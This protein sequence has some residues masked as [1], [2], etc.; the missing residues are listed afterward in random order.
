MKNLS[1]TRLLLPSSILLALLLF[2]GC[3][4]ETTEVSP[5]VAILG[6]KGETSDSRPA[7]SPDSLFKEYWYAGEAEISSFRLKQARYGE[8]REGHA[9]LIYVTEPFLRDK[10]VKADE[11]HSD[12]IPVLKLNS[13]KNFLTGIYPYSIMSST[14]YPVNDSGHAVKVT[15]TVQEWCGHVYSQ[16]NNRGNFE[17]ESYSYFASE[18]DQEAE[19]PAALLENEIWTRIRIRPQELPQG[20]HKVI[21]SFE[22]IRLSHKPLKAYDATLSLKQNTDV[23]EFILEYPELQRTLSITFENNFP[24]AIRGWQE[25]YKSGFGED[26][27]MLTSEAEALKTLKTAYWEKNGNKDVFLRDSLGL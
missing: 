18:G 25:T 13:T 26:A 17:L 4:S 20:T 5:E 24:Y 15:N 27:I 9:V 7:F 14:F 11:H 19:I 10:Q 2:P 16:L 22:Y 3:K 23:S 6:D 8:L 21:P 12:N 1:V